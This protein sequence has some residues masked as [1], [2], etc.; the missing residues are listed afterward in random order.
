MQKFFTF[1]IN[2]ETKLEIESIF[3]N[4]GDQNQVER[5]RI[6]IMNKIHDFI[7]QI[8]IKNK[9]FEIEREDASKL[10]F[11]LDEIEV[12]F[13]QIEQELVIVENKPLFYLEWNILIPLS[14]KGQD[15]FGKCFNV[16][17]LDLIESVINSCFGK[18]VCTGSFKPTMMPFNNHVPGKVV[19]QD[20]INQILEMYPESISVHEDS[21]SIS[22]PGTH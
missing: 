12:F 1:R 11:N 17:K 3:K 2:M 5:A 9:P 15:F 20:G 4:L 22:R 13:S 19:I 18:A 6:I 21:P 8:K 14:S 10:A 7:Q 16:R